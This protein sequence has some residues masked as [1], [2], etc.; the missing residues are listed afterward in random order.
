MNEVDYEALPSNAGLGVSYPWNTA[1]IQ[2][3][4]PIIGQ[5]ACRCTC[6][7]DVYRTDYNR[8]NKTLL[9]AG[10]SEH[11]IMFPIDSIKVSCQRFIMFSSQNLSRH[12]CKFSRPPQWR[13]TVVWGMLS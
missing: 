8:I 1:R 12:G 13:Y 2:L 10:V 7:E 6:K 9:Q 4:H 5:Y 3:T 11:A